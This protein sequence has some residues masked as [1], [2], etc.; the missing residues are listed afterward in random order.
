[1]CTEVHTYVCIYV[2][3]YVCM[4]VFVY[5]IVWLAVVF[6]INSAS[7]AGR[8]IVIVRGEYCYKLIQYILKSRFKSAAAK[9]AHRRGVVV[10]GISGA[11]AMARDIGSIGNGNTLVL[12]VFIIAE[13]ISNSSIELLNIAFG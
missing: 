5:V 4:Y 6:G 9:S 8:K 12:P 1:M 10:S 3:V 13:V 7:N 11:R 2:C